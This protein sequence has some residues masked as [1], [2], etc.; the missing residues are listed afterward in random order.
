MLERILD[1][2]KL[3]NQSALNTLTAKPPPVYPLMAQE[4]KLLSKLDPNIFKVKTPIKTEMLELLTK[5]YPNRLYIE[6]ILS[7]L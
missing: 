4:K 1:P 5:D 2:K 6:Y 7:G 3:Y